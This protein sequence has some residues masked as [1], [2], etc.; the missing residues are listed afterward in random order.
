LPFDGYGQSGLGLCAVADYTEDKNVLCS[1]RSA[2]ELVA[3]A[4]LS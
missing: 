3:P 2:H 1:Q 4:D